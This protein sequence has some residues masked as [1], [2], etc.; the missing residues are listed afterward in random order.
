MEFD[1]LFWKLFF[2]LLGC[3]TMSILAGIGFYAVANW[4]LRK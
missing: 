1:Y 2:T 3:I 4:F